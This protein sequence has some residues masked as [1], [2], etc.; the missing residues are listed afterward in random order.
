MCFLEEPERHSKRSVAIS[1]R[2]TEKSRAVPLKNK[3][4]V[5]LSYTKNSGVG[6]NPTMLKFGRKLSLLPK[7]LHLSLD[8]V[9]FFILP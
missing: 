4:S 9:V 2:L 6:E 5:C 3:G 7:T 8:S 1:R